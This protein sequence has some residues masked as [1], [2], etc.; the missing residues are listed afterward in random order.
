M[1]ENNNIPPKQPPK[2]IP[3][4][5]HIETKNSNE[6]IISSEEII[7]PE[8]E[9]IETTNTQNQT[10]ME[11][12]HHAH[13]PAAPHHKK[14]WKGYFWEFLMLFLAVFCGFLAEY[15]LEHVIEKDRE[16][17]YMKGVVEN[18]QYDI[19]RCNK[20]A[21]NNIAY[22]FGWDSLRYELKKAIS[23]QINGNA[24]YYYAIKYSEVDE[25]AFNTSTITELK[26]SGSLRLIR[27]KKIV[28]DMADYYERKV[29]AARGYLP[30][31]EQNDAL[32]KTKNQFF[33]FTTLDSYIQSY[34]N[35]SETSN[36]FST[37]DYSNI[38]NYDPALQLLTNNPKELEILYTQVSL[39]EIQVKRYN[40]WLGI[41]KNAAEKLIIDIENEYHLK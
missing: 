36:A 25:A 11:V 31:K 27:S 40:T 18:L 35:I 10:D 23:G 39:F 12:H 20:N 37:Y 13:N 24:L 26:N 7:L 2:N 8:T 29:Y 32:Q 21:Q 41:C 15:Q 28:A 38:L 19:I 5:E 3:A 14:N 17:A 16:K 4:V 22:C 33:S 30:S 9:T 34:N 6:E 1:E